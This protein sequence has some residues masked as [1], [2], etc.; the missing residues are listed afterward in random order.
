MAVDQ[1]SDLLERLGVGVLGILPAVKCLEVPARIGREQVPLRRAGGRRI[2]RDDLDAGGEQVVPVLQVLRVSCAGDEGD[3]GAEGH[4]ALRFIVG[5]VLLPVLV[6]EA[7]LHQPGDVRLEGEI[8]QVGGDVAGD[9]AGL[10]ARGTVGLGES[11]VLPRFGLPV[12]VDDGFEAGLGHRVRDKVHPVV[13]GGDIGAVRVIGGATG[14]GEDD[15]EGDDTGR[16]EH[17]S[18]LHASSC[19][20]SD[21]LLCLQQ[22]GTLSGHQ[23]PRRVIGQV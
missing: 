5:D 10:V 23:C 21:R 12:A 18:C 13:A 17:C 19:R 2:G 9:L 20:Y 3:D 14:Q 8:H 15:A 16:G 6:D 22:D 7:F 4:R 1:L 11:G